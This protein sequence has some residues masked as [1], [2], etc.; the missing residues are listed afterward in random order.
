MKRGIGSFALLTAEMTAI[1]DAPHEISDAAFS[2]LMPPIAIIG[3]EIRV[4]VFCRISVP[5]G[6]DLFSFDEV[7]IDMAESDIVSSFVFCPRLLLVM[8]LKLR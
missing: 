8:K 2:L 3:S 6:E 7:G 5:S 1:P 4:A